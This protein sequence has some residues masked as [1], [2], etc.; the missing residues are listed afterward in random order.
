MIPA[1]LPVLRTS[2]HFRSLAIPH[3][4]ALAGRAAD[5]YPRRAKGEGGRPAR[6]AK[7][8]GG[9]PAACPRVK[10][11]R[12]RACTWR[13]GRRSFDREP[14]CRH[15]GRVGRPGRQP[16]L[17]RTRWRRLA[18]GP[19]GHAQARAPAG[20]G[21]REPGHPRGEGA[22]EGRAPAR[23]GRP[24]GAPLRHVCDGRAGESGV[25]GRPRRSAVRRC[26]LSFFFL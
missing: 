14:T 5:C 22:R 6:R 13:A 8:E 23:G 21:A 16:W 10:G 25:W 12:W 20:E 3:G 2:A 4:S 26:R 7:G 15:P 24:R 11:R 19:P 17:L 1:R 9:R 18:A